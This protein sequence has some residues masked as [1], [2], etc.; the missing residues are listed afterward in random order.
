MARDPSRLNRVLPGPSSPTIPRWR[1]RRTPGWRLR[2][3]ISWRAAR[4]RPWMHAMIGE[5]GDWADQTPPVETLLATPGPVCSWLPAKKQQDHTGIS[6]LAWLIASSRYLN[7]AARACKPA[8]GCDQTLESHHSR[9]RSSV[10]AKAVCPRRLIRKV[11]PQC[12]S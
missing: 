5:R 2:L 9:R 3:G 11:T 8:V 7:D 1:K 10:T 6:S 4:G 12:Q